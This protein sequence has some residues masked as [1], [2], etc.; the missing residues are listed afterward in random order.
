MLQSYCFSAI[1]FDTI[2]TIT[3]TFL[4]SAKKKQKPLTVLPG[5]GG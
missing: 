3:D 2:L 4:S 5:I 1:P